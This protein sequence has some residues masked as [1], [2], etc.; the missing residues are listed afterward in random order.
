MFTEG[1]SV[2]L[3]RGFLLFFVGFQEIVE[4]CESTKEALRLRW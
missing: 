4:V 2:R 1:A 3:G